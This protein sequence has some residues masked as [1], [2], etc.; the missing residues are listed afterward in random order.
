MLAG[1]WE[2]ERPPSLPRAAFGVL[3]T[4]VLAA[5]MTVAG[6]RISHQQTGE[7]RWT[8]RSHPKASPVAAARA[9]LRDILYGEEARQEPKETVTALYTAAPEGREVDDGSYAGV[10]LWPEV[11][12]HITLVAPLP[13]FGS[14]GSLELSSPLSIPFAGEYWMFKPPYVRPPLTSYFQRASPVTLSFK[15]RDHRP[16]FMQARQKLDHS[17]DLRCCSEM[18]L[19][20]LNADRYPGTLSLELVLIATGPQGRSSLSL[21]RAPVTSRPNLRGDSVIPVPE[22]LSFLVPAQ[23]P[24]REFNEFQIIFHRNLLRID[25]SA[26]LSID[27][28]VLVPR[29]M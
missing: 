8:R 16:M 22:V 15:T 21:G 10:I 23:A 3:L 5:G 2:V 20:V 7:S 1:T 26:K 18:R 24:L 11:E 28:F 14:Y 17:L 13:V 29:H 4:I 19:A 12:S 9:L 25:R 27:R 6:I